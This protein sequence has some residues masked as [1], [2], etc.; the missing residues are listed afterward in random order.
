MQDCNPISTPLD[1]S[2]KL[3]KATDTEL[4]RMENPTWSQR[5][6]CYE[7]GV[8]ALRETNLN[9]MNSQPQHSH[10]RFHSSGDA[11]A[12]SQSSNS[13]IPCSEPPKT[14]F[15]LP[16]HRVTP[17]IDETVNERG[18][19]VINEFLATTGCS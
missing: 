16:S 9:P 12:L 15:Q 11:I 10:L 18:A 3:T 2:I 14:K 19:V 17:T 4:L 8:T 13:K 5:H 6:D 7:L 1:T